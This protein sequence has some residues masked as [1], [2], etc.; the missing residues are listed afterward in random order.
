MVE[1]MRI[2]VIRGKLKKINIGMSVDLTPLFE[3]GF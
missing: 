1:F 2:Y 3:T